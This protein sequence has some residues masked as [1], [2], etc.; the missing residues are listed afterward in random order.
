MS[1]PSSRTRN[2]FKGGSIVVYGVL[3]DIILQEILFIIFFTEVIFLKKLTVFAKTQ[4][5]VIFSVPP[6]LRHSFWKS[7]KK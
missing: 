7:D 4:E 6:P 2:C 1:P 5:N 3:N